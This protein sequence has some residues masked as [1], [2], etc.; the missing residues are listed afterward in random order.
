MIRSKAFTYIRWLRP[1]VLQGSAAPRCDFVPS[2]MRVFSYGSELFS[3]V[4][5]NPWATGFAGV[6]L[7]V[8]AEASVIGFSLARLFTNKPEDGSWLNARTFFAFGVFL[9]TLVALVFNIEVTVTRSANSIA[10]AKSFVFYGLTWAGWLEA[11]LPPVFVLLGAHGLV[12]IF[13]RQMEDNH[14]QNAA[15]DAA[16]HDWKQACQNIYEDWQDFRTNIESTPEFQ[17]AYRAQLRQAL[18]EANRQL[19]YA[20]MDKLPNRLWANRIAK[21]LHAENELDTEINA[22]LDAKALRA[23]KE[24]D[25][26]ESVPPNFSNGS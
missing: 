6:S 10:E 26:I 7:V 16:H 25:A 4:I 14:A 1:S 2:A 9:A 8:M 15:F 21:E 24:E 5:A 3:H 13:L 19:G 23:A 20:A 12:E 17:R 11:T 22:L 18:R